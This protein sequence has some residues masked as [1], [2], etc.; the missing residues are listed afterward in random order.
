[1]NRKPDW[2][3]F[4][5]KCPNVPEEIIRLHC[6]SLSAEYFSYFPTD[7]VGEH[8]RKLYTLSEK[9]PVQTIVRT[10]GKEKVECTV[11]APDYPSVFSF[12]TG[13][14]SAK[15]F[16]IISG[17][18]FTYMK[19]KPNPENKKHLY[20]RHSSG[21]NIPMQ[22]RRK[23]IDYFTGT[24][25]KHESLGV[26][27]EEFKKSLL[28]I[29]H[30]I[31]EKGKYEVDAAKRRVHEYVAEALSMKHISN[32]VI[33][34]PVEI[35][36]EHLKQRTKLSLTSVDTPFFLYAVSTALSLHRVSIESVQI[37][38]IDTKVIDEFDIVDLKGNA[39][40]SSRQLD[41]IKFSIL[42][43]KQFTYFLW[44]A[45][46]PFQALQRFEKII[47]DMADNSPGIG[48]EKYLTDPTILQDLARLLGAS[49]FLWEDFIRTQYETILPLL[50][51][52]IKERD[53]S[54]SPREMERLLKMEI[55]ACSEIEDKKS[56]LNR[57]KDKETYLIDLDHIL[58]E[59]ADF[60]FLSG[61]LTALAEI[62]V[63]TAVTVMWEEI[64]PLYGMP[65]TVAGITATYTILGL[66]KFGGAALG[67]ASDIEL[68]FVYSDQGQTDGPEPVSNAV[69][70]EEL[71]KKAVL[72]IETKREGIFRVDLRLRPHGQSGPIA[73]S[74]EEFCR[75]YGSDGQAH[76]FEL[77][78]L[79][80]M[81][82]IGGDE[83]LG[84]RIERLRNEYVFA[85]NNI[86]L[87]ELKALREKQLAEK[88]ELNTLN[89][90][91][92]P[93]ALVDL[94]YTVQ[95]L[96]Y[97]YGRDYPAL[98]TSRIH[99]ALKDLSRLGI[100]TN[101]QFDEIVEAYHFFRK[102]INGLRMLRGSA[103]DLFLPAENDDEYL[104]LA[105]RME[106]K[107]REGF[108]P[109]QLLS[110]DFQTTAATI[111]RFVEHYLGRDWIPAEG[112][113]NAADL[114]LSDSIPFE[115]RN[116]IF[117]QAG[118]FSPQRAYVNLKALA[119]NGQ[120]KQLFARLSVLA[121]DVLSHTPDPDMAL[122]NWERFEHSIA[123]I[124]N[125]YNELLHQPKRMELLLQVFASSQFLADILIKYPEF[126][127]WVTDPVR[128]HNLREKE[129]ITEDLHRETAHASD[130]EEWKKILRK[131]RKREILRI[132]TRDICLFVSIEE[133]VRELS[134]LA[135]AILETTL[136]YILFG[137]PDIP[138]SILAFGKLGGRELNYSSDLD[139]IGIVDSN[140]VS[141]SKQMYEKYTEAMERL[142]SLLADHTDEGYVYR[143]DFRLRPYGQSGNLVYSDEALIDY[144]RNNASLWEIQALLKLRP[145]AGDLELG[146][147][148]CKM[149]RP[150]LIKNHIRIEVIETIKTLRQEAV[151]KIS[152]SVLNGQDIKTGKGGIRDIEFL[153]QGFQ[154]VFCKKYPEIVTGNTMEGIRR[155]Q[156][157]A[158]VPGSVA[159]ELIQHYTFL[160]R[161]EH[162]LQ[163]LEDRQTHA[164]PKGQ[165]ERDLLAKRF[166]RGYSDSKHFYTLLDET[167]SRVHM[168]YERYLLGLKEEPTATDN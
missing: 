103:K 102:L 74:L 167:L 73:C 115:Q 159:D 150:F 14:L 64:T 30:I 16:D 123:D 89:A 164:L 142:R 144:Y 124:E 105:R 109:S 60:L 9:T 158:L 87:H 133:I 117:S 25:S 125:H 54:H 121:W 49:D 32:Q 63:R 155:L 113:G 39:I 149:V 38:T 112:S 66:G 153:L 107:P 157:K 96:Q 151:K 100:I 92:S 43:T 31:I 101:Q 8:I 116:T 139:I 58:K 68:L 136:K 3:T 13:L 46:D 111:R 67:Y 71:F 156:E 56:A 132:A 37:Q 127:N 11:L 83:E 145:V 104:H 143:L 141:S 97:L 41:Q 82:W 99:K 59:E 94:E 20:K 85:T 80:R 36:I 27:Q 91:F 110:L 2:S 152:Q 84:E 90:K 81:R 98:Q 126:Y 120:R 88:T 28:E 131:F 7:T 165:R 10:L 24:L 42:F 137:E 118:F 23:I 106:Y 114:V 62:I 34:Y 138:F 40:T 26:W 78:A 55:E 166:S 76:A 108:N 61:K 57:F 52:E 47:Q 69:F 18:S 162:F 21:S 17:S 48:Q 122:N 19:Q 53:F 65:R 1:M 15:G 163:I 77:L 135:D 79:I 160:R 72:L 12:I 93:G 130:D 146:K 128:T 22:K 161:V 35:R 119:G 6:D 147:Q 154:M 140:A 70:F 129:E 95:I 134:N 5:T 51:P 29:F 4:Q 45:P 86:D 168:T 33:L 148:F 50:T 44:E 75:Y